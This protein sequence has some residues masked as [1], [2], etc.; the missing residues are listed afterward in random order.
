MQN[1]E[2]KAQ[3]NED[4]TKIREALIWK[5]K[6]F[7]L[8]CLFSA[9]FLMIKLELSYEPFFGENILYFLIAFTIMD[10]FIDQILSR[11]LM[12]EALLV[13]PVLR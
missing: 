9:L 2:E 7:F 3:L 10:I 4:E 6:H 11:A 8:S 13:S 1:I 5:R 12:G